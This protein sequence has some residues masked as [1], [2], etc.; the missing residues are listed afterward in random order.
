[1]VWKTLSEGFGIAKG[2]ALRSA[3]DRLLNGLGLGPCPDGSRATN[4]VAFT[5]AVVALSAK[6]AKADGVVTK[7]EA[8]AFQRVFQTPPAEAKNVQRIFDLAK[9]DVAGV[10]SY[11][12]QIANLLAG[13][14]QLKR[15]VFEGLFH[16]AASDGILHRDEE[17]HLRTV[18]E[19]FGFTDRDYRAVRSMFVDAPDDPYVVLGVPHSISDGDLKTHYRKLARENHPD[20]HASRGVPPEFME[21]ATRKIAAINA[22][23]DTIARERGL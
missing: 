11:A 1:M 12:R 16:I 19:I 4:T 17:H 20:A 3:L 14:A 10:E 5:V 7:V 23:Y 2:G 6:I 21:M 18:A 22:A 13:D 15:D 9:Q 8:E